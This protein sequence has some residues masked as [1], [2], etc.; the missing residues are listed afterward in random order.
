VIAEGEEGK[1]T[2]I[3]CLPHFRSGIKHPSLSTINTG[4]KRT[5]SQTQGKGKVRGR[6]KS[7]SRA[8]IR[9]SFNKRAEKYIHLKG[10]AW[11]G[12][13]Y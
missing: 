10:P 7:S 6:E 2:V 12:A 3:R 4:G 1:D 11:G 13:L 9:D 8:H 5:T